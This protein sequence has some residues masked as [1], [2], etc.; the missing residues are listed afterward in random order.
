MAATDEERA[1]ELRSVDRRLGMA[2][3]VVAIMSVIFVLALGPRLG[4]FERQNYQL[5]QELEGAQK[6]MAALRADVAQGLARVGGDGTCECP[7]AA[8]RKLH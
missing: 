6:E 2:A 4:G 7:V 5:R 1:I 8:L 3:L